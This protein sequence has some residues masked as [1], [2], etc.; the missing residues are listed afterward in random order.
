MLYNLA[1][2]IA[3]KYVSLLASHCDRIEIAGSVRRKKA[4]VGD[5]EIVCIP[6]EIRGVRFPEFINFVNNLTK[7]RGEPTGKYTQRMLPEGIAI[8]IF[9]CNA[10]NWGTIFAMRTGS[11]KYSHYVLA[12]T[13]VKMGYHSSGGLLYKD[14][15]ILSFREELDL[16]NFLGLKYVDPEFRNL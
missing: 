11:A 8:D 3:D 7:V 5:I 10:E 12:S 6:S 14:D 16:F 9:M 1:K 4:D 15:E 2:P 13:W